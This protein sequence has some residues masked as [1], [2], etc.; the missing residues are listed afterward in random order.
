L[1]FDVPGSTECMLILMQDLAL[2]DHLIA[3]GVAQVVTFQLK[4]HPT[5]VSD[6]LEKDLVETVEHYASLLED[7]FPH[8]KAAGIRWQQYLK[9]MLSAV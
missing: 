8:A 9:G 4:S 6:A 5:F 2:A 3:S 7:K 1:T